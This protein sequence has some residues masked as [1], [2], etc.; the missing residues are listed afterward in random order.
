MLIKSGKDRLVGAIADFESGGIFNS[1]SYRRSYWFC[2][3]DS[4]QLPSI[5]KALVIIRNY[6]E[7]YKLRPKASYQ[8]NFVTK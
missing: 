5:T 8:G 2:Y 7:I 4:Q 6:R 3:F 1:N